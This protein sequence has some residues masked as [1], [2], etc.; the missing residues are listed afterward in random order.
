MTR[1]TCMR[2]LVPA[3]IGMVLS[4]TT[5]G[6]S[7]VVPMSL[8]DLAREATLI[9]DARVMAVQ[10][11]ADTGRIERI[12]TLRVAALWKGESE[13]VLH[14]RVPGGTLGRM[15]T[16]M[17]GVPEF[18]PGDRLVLFLDAHPAA[19][20]RILGLHQGAWRVQVSPLDGRAHVG[21]AG[22]T[23]DAGGPLTRG[24]LAQ[25]PIPVDQFRSIVAGLLRSTP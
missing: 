2:A 23:S 10:S 7:V 25:R 17:T 6:A 21:P 18:E 16:V 22:R 5:A 8:S 4:A 12:V 15:R 3:L 19:G 1:T 11:V 14:L 20:L 9:V 13:D 24:A